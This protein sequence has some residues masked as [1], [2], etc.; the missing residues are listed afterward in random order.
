M[1]FGFA[2][3]THIITL[4]V[5]DNLGAR[6]QVATGTV[7]VIEQP[8]PVSS[9][10]PMSGRD[11]QRSGLSPFAGPSV[12]PHA[13]T[14]VFS[15]GAA[16]VGDIDLSSEGNLYFATA[17][18]L[19]ALK[20]D[21]TQLVP[22]SLAGSM[23]NGATFITEPVIDDR[24]GSVYIGIRNLD[25]TSSIVRYDKQLQN[26][27]LVAQGDGYF[28]S[29][30]VIGDN[31][32]L[33]HASSTAV[34]AI[35]NGITWSVTGYTWCQP[36][37][38]GRD[39]AV[40]TVCFS[41]PSGKGLYKFNGTNGAQLKFAGGF[42]GTDPMI[43]A[44]GRLWSGYMAFS[45]VVFGGAY[46]AWDNDLNYLGLF[47][48]YTTGRATL[49]PDGSNVRPG[50]RFGNTSVLSALAAVSCGNSLCPEP[51]WGRDLAS[52]DERFDTLASAD[53]EGNVFV[54]T[55]LGVYCLDAAN[56]NTKWNINLGD[57]ITTQ[58]AISNDGKVYV[59]SFGG[60]VYAL[61][62]Q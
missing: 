5:T 15:A 45:G 56:G 23:S 39:G 40:F 9:V 14:W 57:V 30:L 62:G 18:A 38:L 4:V 10:W 36:P 41:G 33:Y 27:T 43:D 17:T 28:L 50:Y 52:P 11:P 47:S 51:R 25:R 1:Q 3:G 31:S 48:D 2:K 24:N 12:Q 61:G 16:I 44:R 53:A 29:S 13:P 32:V 26:A 6:S 19:Y 34:G 35:G 42:A 7:I 54:G 37:A 49:L 8:P 21:G 55:T 20:R 22:P 46:S 59:G 58:P 60:N